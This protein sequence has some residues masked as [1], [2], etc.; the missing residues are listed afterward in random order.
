MFSRSFVFSLLSF[1][2][3]G[4]TAKKIIIHGYLPFAVAER[5]PFTYM[6]GAN[7]AERHH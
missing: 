5:V 2:N 4:P 7:S 6:H 1:L 3:F